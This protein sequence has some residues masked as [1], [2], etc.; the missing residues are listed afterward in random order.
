MTSVWAQMFSVDNLKYKITDPVNHCAVVIGYETKPEGVLNVPGKVNYN[1][2][3]YFVLSIE[4]NAFLN[5]YKIVEVNLPSS[6][7]SIEEAAFKACSGVQK[8]T[9]PG[10]LTTLGKQAFM[11]CISLNEINLG[12]IGTVV[13]AVHSIDHIGKHG[14]G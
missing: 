7:I 5:C 12:F 4:N 6:V 13:S 10:T 11:D 9:F 2:T 3:D 14:V 8:V 1:G